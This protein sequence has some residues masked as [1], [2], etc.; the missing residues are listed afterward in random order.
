MADGRSNVASEMVYSGAREKWRIGIPIVGHP[1]PRSLFRPATNRTPQD[2][3]EFLMNNSIKNDIVAQLDK[4]LISNDEASAKLLDILEDDTVLAEELAKDAAAE[5]DAGSELSELDLADSRVQ[6]T[7]FHATE[8][9]K[10]FV[11]LLP[12]ATLAHMV[13]ILKATAHGAA[14]PEGYQPGK[15]VRLTDS[16][17]A[18]VKKTADA[19]KADLMANKAMYCDEAMDNGGDLVAYTVRV[20]AAK[21]T[22]K[23]TF[24]KTHGEKPKATSHAAQVRA[25]YAAIASKA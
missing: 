4:G 12:V 1:I 7:Q 21:T 16:Q 5:A 20:G 3:T 17:R 14:I 25:A 2:G 23:L 18:S 9:R 15:Y 19:R 24:Q 22:T 10:A 6:L 13:V 11:S 8:A